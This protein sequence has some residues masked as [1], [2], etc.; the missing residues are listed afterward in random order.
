VGVSGLEVP[1][2]DVHLIPLN[3]VADINFER[4]KLDVSQD[5]LAAT[6]A[7]IRQA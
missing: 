3:G 7:K 4:P 1:H 6:A 5:D 2:A